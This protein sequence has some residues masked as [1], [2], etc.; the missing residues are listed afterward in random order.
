MLP[1]PEC[2]MGGYHNYSITGSRLA[3]IHWKELLKLLFISS[4]HHAVIINTV[5]HVY[6]HMIICK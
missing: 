4:R 2:L 5:P 6:A 1:P 3:I